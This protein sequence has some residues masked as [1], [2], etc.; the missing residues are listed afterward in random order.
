[1]AVDEEGAMASTSR[2]TVIVGGSLA[3]VRAAEALRKQGYDGS[4][5][6]VGAEP[7]FPPVDRPTLSKELL[8]GELT[9]EQA[10]L[11]IQPFEVTTMLG[12]VATRLDLAARAVELEDE[13]LVPFDS[14]VLATGTSPRLLPV[15]ENARGVHVLRTAEDCLAIRA[16]LTDVSRVV[17]VGAGFV[18][19]EVAATCREMGVQ[20][21]IVEPLEIPL[22]RAFG[23][24]AGTFVAG[25][26]R[27]NGVDLRL[28]VAVTDVV[29]GRDPDGFP[30]V[31]AIVLSDGE[32]LACDL[33]I[34]AIGV[35]PAT[36]WLEG[37]GLLL[38]DGIVCDPVL[39]A[40]DVDG[41]PV[42]GVVAAG[43]VARWHHPVFQRLV[44]VEHWTNAIEQGRHAASTLLAPAHD[45]VPFAEIPFFWSK[46]YGRLIQFVGL[47]GPEEVELET[48]GTSRVIT[49]SEEGRLTGALVVNGPRLVR[50]YRDD[51]VAAHSGRPARDLVRPPA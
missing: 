13:S 38:D 5:T 27:E 46:Q 14:L 51:I 18:G 30:T 22:Q 12:R 9:L 20:V 48:S 33:L 6:M 39:R 32:E 43:D 47:P 31:R 49:Y 23:P 36:D 25:L 21:A 29:E 42:P 7:E 10:Q 44:R 24:R 17:V 3:G 15:S 35:V 40:L 19:C 41:V 34:V 37:S 16:A 50:G 11:R 4:L 1:V 26:H 28:G 45:R 8:A 2:R